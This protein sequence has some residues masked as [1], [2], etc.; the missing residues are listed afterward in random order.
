MVALG[1][2]QKQGVNNEEKFAP[3]A[4][5]ITFRLMLALA[6]I[7]NLWIHQLDVDSAFQYAPLYE[8]VFMKPT[9]DMEVEPCYCLRLLKSL[10]GLKQAPR[11]WHLHFAK[12]IKSL[13]FVQSVLDNCLFIML[14]DGE[15]FF[16]TLYE[17]AGGTEGKVH[18]Q[19]RDERSQRSESISWN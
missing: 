15:L 7:C 3:V 4:K 11:N 6:Q 17:T 18:D 19:L 1:Y 2:Q 5:P 14:A 9:M 16:L 10:Y 13:E 12:F 8:E